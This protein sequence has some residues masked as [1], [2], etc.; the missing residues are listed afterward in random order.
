MV[1]WSARLSRLRVA[2]RRRELADRAAL[3]LHRRE[4]F[5]HGV[6]LGLEDQLLGVETD[7][8]VFQPASLSL[9]KVTSTQ[10]TVGMIQA[11]SANRFTA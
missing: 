11:W 10:L 3:A 2:D 8:K 1:S 7:L 4:G 9:A 5:F 6:E